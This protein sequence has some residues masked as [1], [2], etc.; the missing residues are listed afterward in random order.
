M[1]RTAPWMLLP[2][3]ALGALA[4]CDDAP[5][6]DADADADADAEADAEGDA[7]GDVELERPPLAC[8]EPGPLGDGP[9]FTDVTEAL[10]LGPGGLSIQGGQVSTADID[11]DRLPDLILHTGA[12]NDQRDDPEDPRYLG[13]VLRN[14]GDGEFDDVTLDCG[15][16]EAR[17]GAWGRVSHFM[18]FGDVDNDGDAD[19]FAAAYVDADTAAIGDHSEVLINQGDGTFV[20]GPEG[21]FCE[22]PDFEPLASATLVDYDLDGVLD[23]YT[24]HHYGRYGVLASTIQDSLYRGRGDGSFE[25]VTDEA[26]VRTAMTPESYEEAANH[27]PTWGVAA[28]DLDSDGWPELM[29]VSYGRQLNLLWHARG[30]GTYENATLAAAFGSDDLVDYSDNEFY[31][32]HCHE[33]GGFCDPEPPNPRIAC[34]SSD[35]WSFYDGEPWRLGGNN[36]AAV[37]GD[38]DNDGDI[39]VLMTDIAHWHI[40]DSS[41][42][43][44]LLINEG[45]GTGGA[46]ERPGNDETGLT[47][48]H[49]SGWNEGDLGGA[50]LDFDNDGRLDVLVLSSDYPDTYS[51]LWHQGPD[52]QFEEVGE[53]GGARVDRAHGATAIDYDRDGD[54]DLVIGTSLAR[55][56]ATDDPPRP[57]A[58]YMYVL[59]NDVGQ[60]SNRVMVHLE[61]E[62]E[63]GANRSAIGARI[64][65]R[66]G[67]DL[68]VREVYA[69]MGLDAYQHDPLQIIGVGDHC[70][71]DSVTIRWPDQDHT[72]TTIPQVP[73]NY[74]L[75]VRQG[76]APSFATLEEY[77]AGE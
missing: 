55:W 40:G 7:D 26:G 50:L 20:L 11:G 76:Q 67:D 28:C 39:D 47:R 34:G 57:D 74:V 36:S 16:F 75:E 1:Q 10:G 52:G 44:Q 23:L 18:I 29:S 30:D 59:R 31:R 43:T 73:A 63:G 42:K 3:L 46:F 54:Y 32:C 56:A 4:G 37:C 24:G 69:G 64:E 33:F 14:L 35:A 71:V 6:A 9:Y 19:A 58:A 27:R 21:D 60:G 48:D 45:V 61:G 65:V 41:D 25:D 5:P 72:V 13:R 17:D 62:G 38:V 2:W 53:R 66:A 15:L 68:Y 22:D 70:E 49:A 12:R 8:L 77:V 51:L